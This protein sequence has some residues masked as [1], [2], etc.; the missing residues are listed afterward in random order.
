MFSKPR[1]GASHHLPVACALQGS[2]VLTSLMQR[3]QAS[4]ARL[5]AITPLLP[6]GLQG[7]VQPG[8]LDDKSWSL[9]VANSAAAAKLRHLLPQ[10]QSAL[11]T[12]GFADVPIRLRVQ[13]KRP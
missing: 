13:V 5:Q 2:E 1:P 9:L 8:P 7:T 4:R 12:R 3:L 11:V 6:E 10:L